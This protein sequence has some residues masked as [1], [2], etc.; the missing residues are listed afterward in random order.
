MHPGLGKRKGKKFVPRSLSE[1]LYLHIKKTLLQF[2]SF[3]RVL[4][5]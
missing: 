2:L 1:A 3:E 4:L 5:G